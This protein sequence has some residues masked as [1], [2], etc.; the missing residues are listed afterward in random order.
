VVQ[1]RQRDRVQRCLSEQGI[2]SAIHYPTPIHL[3]P[4]CR[5]Y[6]YTRGMLP[7]TEAVCERIISLP[8]YPELISQQLQTVIDGVK[9]SLG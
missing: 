5:H 3:Q 6:G 9:R 2:G 8:M 1:V 4:A 7:V